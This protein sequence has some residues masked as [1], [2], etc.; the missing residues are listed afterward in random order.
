MV[1]AEKQKA[2]MVIVMNKQKEPNKKNVTG[3]KIKEYHSK[4]LKE[5]SSRSLFNLQI[6]NDDFRMRKERIK[7]DCC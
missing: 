1:A 5:M 7:D 6:E 2:K 4:I 3:S